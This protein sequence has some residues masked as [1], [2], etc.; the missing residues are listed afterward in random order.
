MKTVK[1]EL[2]SYNFPVIFLIMFD[3]FSHH[4]HL[5]HLSPMS[6]FYTPMRVSENLW[7][8]DA[9]MEVQ[10]CDIDLKW[11]KLRRNQLRCNFH[12]H[13]NQF[14]LIQGKTFIYV[15]DSHSCDSKGAHVPNGQRGQSSELSFTFQIIESVEFLCYEIS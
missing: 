11:A 7:F 5:T 4:K 15:F 6:Y 9:F 8:S 2:Y 3:L 12:M 14:C 10:K 1:Q 13:W